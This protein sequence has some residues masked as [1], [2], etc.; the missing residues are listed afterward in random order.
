MEVRGTPV[1]VIPAH[2]PNEIP[3]FLRHRRSARLPVANLPAPEE[4][5]ALPMPS[6]DR[7]GLDDQQGGFPVGPHTPPPDPEDPIRRGQLPSLRRKA[8]ENGQLL[9]QGEVLQSK[10]RRGLA[11]R[12]NRAQHGEQV[13][14]H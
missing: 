6:D 13:S 4:A 7:L 5:K 8:T 14:P 3:N 12:G 11:Q 9:S 10:L 2:P 1:R